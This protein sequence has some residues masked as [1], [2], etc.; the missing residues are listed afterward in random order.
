[1]KVI[2]LYITNDFTEK[3]LHG[4]QKNFNYKGS[5]VITLCNQKQNDKITL[6]ASYFLAFSKG[7]IVFFIITLLFK[8]TNSTKK[9]NNKYCI[10]IKRQSKTVNK[11]Y[12]F[13]VNKEVK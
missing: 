5:V 8:K 2:T 4:S 3:P 6:N 11:D 10:P 9:I 13:F 12:Y 1:M 7:I